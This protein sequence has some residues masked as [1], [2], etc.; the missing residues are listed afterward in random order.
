[1]GKRKTKKQ[2]P[3]EKLRLFELWKE[4]KEYELADT[5]NQKL[6][7]MNVP[8]EI[9]PDLT[10]KWQDIINDL[11]L[12]PSTFK[13][14]GVKMKVKVMK[15]EYIRT[16]FFAGVNKRD[17]PFEIENLKLDFENKEVPKNCRHLKNNFIELLKNV[18]QLQN[19][20]E[21]TYLDWKKNK[22][23]YKF[24]EFAKFLKDHL[25]KDKGHAETTKI[26][27]LV[28]L[29]FKTLMVANF[30]LSVFE[31]KNNNLKLK[32]ENIFQF[33]ALM[34]EFCVSY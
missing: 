4:S 31:S 2:T 18:L 19:V 32:E 17:E 13:I 7:E 6:S 26:L 29:P 10:G 15:Q 27:E 34:K 16:A 12:I 28:L 9:T 14:K 25:K 24:K 20:D 11:M 33:N 1:M 8:N 23:V 5:I 30:R 22:I 21:N 3:E